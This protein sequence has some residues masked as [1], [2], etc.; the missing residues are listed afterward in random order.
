[1]NILFKNINERK[2]R[3]CDKNIYTAMQ[4][5]VDVNQRL[6]VPLLRSNQKMYL[7]WNLQIIYGYHF[8]INLSMK[9]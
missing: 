8:L 4:I 5:I 7:D 9:L 6:N 3:R 2:I 1:M